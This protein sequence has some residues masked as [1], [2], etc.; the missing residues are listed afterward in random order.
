MDALFDEALMANTTTFPVRVNYVV[1]L[2]VFPRPTVVILR[3]L[4]WRARLSGI[5]TPK[6][7]SCYFSP[8]L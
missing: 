6:V 1:R 5:N 7:F 3:L 8:N 2:G 4:E